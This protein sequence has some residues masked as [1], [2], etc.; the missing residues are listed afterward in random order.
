MIYL[1][2]LEISSKTYVKRYNRVYSVFL[3]FN[4]QYFLLPSSSPNSMFLAKQ[5]KISIIL[6]PEVALDTLY[7]CSQALSTA[8]IN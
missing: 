4:D 7:G 2:E 6:T 1:L 5:S 3:S 8:F